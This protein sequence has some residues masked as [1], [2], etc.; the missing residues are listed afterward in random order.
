MFNAQFSM[1]NAQFRN[2]CSC[3][4][5]FVVLTSYL[6]L[7]SCSVQ[8]QIA[9]SADK[10]VLDAAPLQTAHVGISIYEPA[11]NKYWYD[12]QGD[13]YFV[14][15]S[16]I[17]IPT[18]YAAMKYL[19]DSLVG[20]KYVS[21]GKAD[22]KD[23]WIQAT[24]DPTFLHPDFIKQPVVDFFKKDSSILFGLVTNNQWKDDAFGSGWSWDDYTA[25]Y[26][27]ERSLFSYLW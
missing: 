1:V 6:F 25:S 19:G 22:N 27:S 24:G 17:K 11:T 3:I 5:Y 8:K 21:L 18:C 20:L 4:S 7:S 15:A 26:M 23:I 13:K 14:P 9:K 12:F 2:T 10:E 16:N